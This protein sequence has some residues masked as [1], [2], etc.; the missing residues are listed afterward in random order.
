MLFFSLVHGAKQT[1]PGTDVCSSELGRCYGIA[2][3]PRDSHQIVPTIGGGGI[4]HC[5]WGG[6]LAFLGSFVFGWFVCPLAILSYRLAVA[7]RLPRSRHLKASETSVC[8][9]VLFLWGGEKQKK[10]GVYN[11]QKIS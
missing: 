6:F 10:G 1:C 11:I 9:S 3:S 4:Q 7:V 5:F 2:V 8:C